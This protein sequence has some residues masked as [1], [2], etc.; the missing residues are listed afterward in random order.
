MNYTP[1]A[2]YLLI[3]PVEAEKT[4][5]GGIIIP[6][7]A[8]EASRPREGY[9][10]AVGTNVQTE[11]LK[12]IGSKVLYKIWGGNVFKDSNGKELLMVLEEDILAIIDEA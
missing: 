7:T 11:E 3:E 5:A 10:R 4:T 8:A 12:R 6:D 9:I 2:D 1:I